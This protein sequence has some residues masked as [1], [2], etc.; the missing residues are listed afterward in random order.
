MTAKSAPTK[1]ARPTIDDQ[2]AGLIT[3]EE[4]R[5]A[6]IWAQVARW[7]LTALVVLLA[8]QGLRVAYV[9]AA[10]VATQTSLIRP[11]TPE[12][13]RWIRATGGRGVTLAST[14]HMRPEG[15]IGKLPAALQR[16]Q[17]VKT[18]PDALN[19]YAR[20]FMRTSPEAVK[21]RQAA[22]KTGGAAILA[23]LFGGMALV[24]ART[25][26]QWE[27]RTMA[28]ITRRKARTRRAA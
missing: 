19:S 5:R 27:R 13:R 28:Q 10:Q 1:K 21:A 9:V 12:Q 18:C 8:V 23:A 25:W 11:L 22:E 17:T 7:T 20:F 15:W 14:A 4:Y 2:V 6:L 24:E 3:S 16:C 26:P